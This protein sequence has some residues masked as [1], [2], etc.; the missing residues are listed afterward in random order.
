MH[1]KVSIGHTV[2]DDP[3]YVIARNQI[4]DVQFINLEMDN[5]SI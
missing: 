4:N 1:G 3:I 5:L 2:S